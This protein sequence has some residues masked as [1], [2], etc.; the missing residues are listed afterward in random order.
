MLQAGPVDE[1]S[2]NILLLGDG[3]QQGQLDTFENDC[4][5]LAT[6]IAAT[7]WFKAEPKLHIYRV[8]VKSTDRGADVPAACNNGAKLTANTYFDAEYGKTG[9]CRMLSGADDLVNEVHKAQVGSG[10]LPIACNAKIVLVNWAKLGAS[11]GGDIMWV[12]ARHRDFVKIILHELGHKAGLA[13]EYDYFI[14]CGKEVTQ[15]TGTAGVTARN[16]TKSGNAPPWPT[17][18][19]IKLPTMTNDHCEKCDRRKST[20]AAGSIGAFAGAYH[21]HCGYYRPTYT[22]RMRNNKSEFCAVCETGLIEWLRV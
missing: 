11:C 7:T 16:V 21:Y 15:D 6:A 14:G 13:D 5:K 20:V 8:N 2:Q 1:S 4:K 17:T 10:A 18:P 3:Y 9:P 19:G 12:S 22:C